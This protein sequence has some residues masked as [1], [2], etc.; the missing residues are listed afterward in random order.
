MK[1]GII[2]DT[3]G[4]FK[5]EWKEY[6]TECDCIIHAGDFVKKECYEAF[7]GLGIPLYA[8]RGNCDYTSWAS[9]LSK[10]IKFP[11]NGKVFYVV[12]DSTEL[13][14]DLT[15]IDFIIY[16]HSHHYEYNEKFGKVYLNPGSAKDGRGTPKS[17]VQ[18]ELNDNS[19]EINRIILE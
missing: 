19:Y 18:L 15:D 7:E 6:L 2:S 5:E 9:F 1:I 13:P 14:F 4:S 8:V 16:G 12:H 3:H 11:L 10:S 17:M